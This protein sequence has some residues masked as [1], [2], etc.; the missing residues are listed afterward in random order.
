MVS[1][2]KHNVILRHYGIIGSKTGDIVEKMKIETFS[3]KKDAKMGMVFTEN[4]FDQEKKVYF[5]TYRFHGA[6]SVL[7]S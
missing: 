5:P 3:H 1:F 4:T 7:R 2:F 6:H